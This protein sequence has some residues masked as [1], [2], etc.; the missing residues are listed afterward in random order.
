MKRSLFFLSVLIL[1]V[2]FSE[3]A[4]PSQII[5]G[6]TYTGKHVFNRGQ[7][8][9]IVDGYVVFDSES[10]VFVGPGTEFKLNLNCKIEFRGKMRM[11]STNKNEI[12]FKVNYTNPGPEDGTEI[13][14]WNI[15]NFFL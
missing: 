11:H 7:G 2:S 15:P 4:K 13:S 9:Y 1:C 8:P 3:A 5:P 6:G 10:E 14:F 12:E